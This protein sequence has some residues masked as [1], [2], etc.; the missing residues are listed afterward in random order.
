MLTLLGLLVPRA[1]IN[2]PS[3]QSDH[4]CEV[5]VSPGF[6]TGWPLAHDA[7]FV[8]GMIEFVDLGVCI[9]VLKRDCVILLQS[10]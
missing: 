6:T 4:S 1:F 8:A 9:N 7:G 2:Q 3:H 10:A 5:V